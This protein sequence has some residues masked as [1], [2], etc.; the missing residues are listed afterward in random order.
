MG[1]SYSQML[2]AASGIFNT[3][4]WATFAST[5]GST[6]VTI[7]FNQNN[8]TFSVVLLELIGL[9]GGKKGATSSHVESSG[10][11]HN[12]GSVTTTTAASVIVLCADPNNVADTGTPSAGWVRQVG[13]STGQYCQTKS[14]GEIATETG[15][16][17][18]GL[19][20]TFVNVM[21]AYED[22]TVPG[23]SSLTFQKP[24]FSAVGW[25]TVTGTGGIVLQ[26]P[27]FSGSGT[28]TFFGGGNLTFG[29]PS[30]SGV[31]WVTAVGS[32]GLVFQKPSFSGS[33]HTTDSGSGGLVFKKPS[34]SG[35]G[36]THSG[37]ARLTQ[38][39][40]YTGYD[41]SAPTA[42]LTQIGRY[43]AYNESTPTARL[44]QMGRYVAYPFRCA[45]TP[46]TP[47]ND[48]PVRILDKFLIPKW[49]LERFDQKV[50]DEETQAGVPVETFTPTATPTWT[51][52][53]I[54]WKLYRMDVAF[55]PQGRMIGPDTTVSAPDAGTAAWQLERFDMTPRYEDRA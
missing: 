47:P 11:S 16:W 23:T 31:G 30:L 45:D 6:A 54:R 8:V 35:S 32:G 4:Q 21:V 41:E 50:R 5:G 14:E 1:G 40:R 17:T 12:G 33:G 29:K 52:D 25:A 55:T 7:T 34:F 39:G 22:A 24:S 28:V 38:I 51:D 18:S 27:S 9:G 2:R 15:N 37:I 53:G 48:I 13:T 26:K 3:Q 19:T 49:E 36:E 46:P 42:R 20:G 10:T 44:T 43:T